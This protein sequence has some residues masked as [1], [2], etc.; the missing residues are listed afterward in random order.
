MRSLR[1]AAAVGLLLAAGLADAACN[2]NILPNAVFENVVDTITLAAVDGTPVNRPSALDIATAPVPRAV[3]TDLLASWDFVFNIDTLGR[4][5]LIPSNMLH[6]AAS[7]GLTISTTPFS[8]LLEAPHNGY[9]QD[10]ATV[11]FPGVTVAIRSRL[12]NCELGQL[13]YYGKLRVLDVNLVT[14]ELK[15]EVLADINCGYRSLAP[16]HA[17]R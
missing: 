7:S 4:A 14:R 6:I 12:I 13:F 8:Q 9:N 2:D 15:F 17:T 11:V 5:L 10:S 1:I 3:R 16:G